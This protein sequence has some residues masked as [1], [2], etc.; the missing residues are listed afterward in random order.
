A[1]LAISKAHFAVRGDTSDGNKIKADI[2]GNL[3]VSFDGSSVAMDISIAYEH[4]ASPDLSIKGSTTAPITFA[5]FNSFD[6]ADG[7]FSATR[8]HR[9]WT[10]DLSG[11]AQLN[12]RDVDVKVDIKPSGDSAV[13][14]TS[15]TLAQLVGEANLPGLDDV[16]FN[17]VSLAKNSASLSGEIEGIRFDLTAFK[18]GPENKLHI[19]IALP[20]ELDLLHFIPQLRDTGLPNVILND[21]SF[22]WVP[23]GASETGVEVD[24]LPFS[25]A[26]IL[27]ASTPD[28]KIDLI[29]GVNVFAYLKGIPS[30]SFTD[31]MHDIGINPV[32]DFVS[33]V[34]PAAV[35]QR[36]SAA[37]SPG[38]EQAILDNLNIHWNVPLP[39]IPGLDSVLSFTDAKL[40]ITGT[41]NAQG[42]TVIDAGIS[43]DANFHV[44][45]DAFKLLVKIEDNRVSG[46]NGVNALTFLAS[47]T[48]SWTHPIG[49]DW[50]TLDNIDLKITKTS[51][52]TANSPSDYSISLDST[53]DIGG[54]PR[55]IS[56]SFTYLEKGISAASFT[57]D[58]PLAL[59]D[60][61][62]IAK[63][64]HVKEFS[65]TN[66]IISPGGIEADT[67]L[68]GNALDFY[69]F[70][71]GSDWNFAAVQKEF[72]FSELIPALD[73]TPAGDFKLSEAALL[74]TSG[75]LN[76]LLSTMPVIAQ[77]A[78]KNIYGSG[79]AEV[80]IPSGLSM[81]AAFGSGGTD[82]MAKGMARMGAGDGGVLIGTIG[83]VFGGTPDISLTMM[84]SV[85]AKPAQTTAATKFKDGE[86]LTLNV[87]LIGDADSFV[88]QL[89]MGTDITTKIDG[90]TLVF[91]SIIELQLSDEVERILFDMT[92]KTGNV[93]DKPLVWSEPY[94]IPGFE[95]HSVTLDLGIDE[96]GAQHFGLA[97][98]FTLA[99]DTISFAVDFDLAAEASEFPQDIAFE[100]TAT[101]I[102]MDFLEA[103]AFQM[104]SGELQKQ[105]VDFGMSSLPV[106]KIEGIL[107]AKTG[108][109]GPVKLAFVSPGAQD[110]NLGLT[111][112]GFGLQGSMH[113]LGQDLGEIFVAIG[114][115]SGIFAWG[116]IA[117]INLGDD[118]LTLKS[119]NFAMRLPVPGLGQ[120]NH[121]V[122]AKANAA[123]KSQ[124]GLL[125]C[126]NSS[127]DVIGISETLRVDAT[128]SGMSFS[129][130]LS[131][132]KYFDENLEFALSGVDLTTTHPSL[133]NADFAISGTLTADVG[134]EIA[135]LMTDGIGDIFSGFTT[136]LQSAETD[137]TN[138][139]ASVATLTTTINQ[140]R[141]SVRAAKQKIVDVVN[142]AQD[143]V[144]SIDK[145]ITHLW[146]KYHGCHGWGK[147][148]CKAGYG[149]EIGSEKGV[150]DVAN[151][152]LDAAKALVNHMP[153]DLSPTVW[154]NILLRTTADGILYAAEKSIE[155]LVD[156]DDWNTKGVDLVANFTGGSVNIKH[157][158]FN[159]SLRALIAS[160]A[161]GGP[162]APVDLA[163]EA[164]IFGTNFSDNF[165]FNIADLESDVASDFS[166]LSL[167]AYY[168]IDRIFMHELDAVPTALTSQLRGAIGK[169]IDADQA[170]NRR[171]LATNAT[172]FAN[173]GRVA[174]QLQ[175]TYTG[176]SNSY[177]FTQMT[178]VVS[179][180]DRLP[181]SNTF[182]GDVIEIGNTGYCLSMPIGGEDP[183]FDACAAQ[184][185]IG[186]YDTV[187]INNQKL[188]TIAIMD[189]SKDT[190]YVAIS[191]SASRGRSCLSIAGSWANQEVSYGSGANSMSA[192]QSVF[193]PTIANAQSLSPAVDG[194]PSWMNCD[195][196]NDQ[197]NWKILEHGGLYFQIINR[198]TQDCAYLQYPS[199]PQDY[200]VSSLAMISC[201]GADSQV[202][203]LAPADPP[204]HHLVGTVIKQAYAQMNPEYDDSPTTHCIAGGGSNGWGKCQNNSANT[205][206]LQQEGMDFNLKWNYFQDYLNRRRFVASINTNDEM[207][208]R[209]NAESAPACL[210]FNTDDGGSS[211]TDPSLLNCDATEETQWLVYYKVIG[212]F[213]LASVATN[214]DSDGENVANSSRFV[215]P[216]F[217]LSMPLNP[218]AGASWELNNSSSSQL[219][220]ANDAAY[221]KSEQTNTAITARVSHW[222]T[223]KSE[224]DSNK[225]IL[226][227]GK[228]YCTSDNTLCY[229][230]G[231]P[232]PYVD[233]AAATTSTPIVNS[234]PGTMLASLTNGT[235]IISDDMSVSSAATV[236]AYRST[237]PPSAKWIICK[238][239]I[240]DGV[241]NGLHFYIPGVIESQG[242]AY[243]LDNQVNKVN[244]MQILTKMVDLAWQ[245]AGAGY[246]PSS[247]VPTGRAPITVAGGILTN[248]SFTHIPPQALFSC[249]SM[250]NRISYIGWTYEGEFCH[251]KYS[252][253]AT[254]TRNFQ[255]LTLEGDL[256][257]PKAAPAVNS[258]QD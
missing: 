132:G 233:K 61:A 113:W 222:A 170:A 12:G 153:I 48:E 5:F 40:V 22:L 118:L 167:M 42:Q 176:F 200:D 187:G 211:S 14:T 198:A 238:G 169:V 15:S 216:Q 116:D 95:L 209:F 195:I 100:G 121:A 21:V 171:R 177:A 125:F 174:T 199:D 35:F 175:N 6:I 204:T 136:F 24:S 188:T 112:I 4:G 119:N 163:I 231:P 82:T 70:K 101:F 206:E 253:K 29:P 178:E 120:F 160:I 97:G 152:V 89:G 67:T 157:A 63:L 129:S 130:S 189:G 39:K 90:D 86:Q 108:I 117:D 103:L 234:N 146:S 134:E 135:L 159:G 13:F 76:G 110:P 183:G 196:G 81:V 139:R 247:A 51:S 226:E 19:G 94:G 122:E 165:A 137:I 54:S 148:L 138:D 142:R 88:G 246:L 168:G 202:F 180:L 68:H 66:L 239:P 155:G 243:E 64:P 221:T 69:A 258:D 179:P 115:L 111:S 99:Q 58:G 37:P 7:K 186:D 161:P 109:V 201:I 96:D 91:D 75:E 71:H 34:M 232:S 192:Y 128:S 53:F 194:A 143:N 44:K 65:I 229:M 49:I 218:V 203:K 242:C 249:R 20:D 141:A 16:S 252:G 26:H 10:V 248:A 223:I 131:F 46:P 166:Q 36:H 257:E 251:L 106:P 59:P 18:R 84:L 28:T 230:T 92:L 60:I 38:I 181:A 197:Q 254:V 156:L 220:G 207:E 185:Q 154:S 9:E 23:E 212:G 79:T 147:Y 33:G 215:D 74:V 225:L 93:Q 164:E 77:N 244:Q 57:L 85:G 102:E 145:E 83:G 144:D 1:T 182:S 250:I 52:T 236:A 3:A 162:A 255:V 43:G 219:N 184:G 73:G 193:T 56:T 47:S 114:P 213:T 205:T 78:L 107:D 190:G 224:L 240:Y 11:R 210:V 124:P 55:K 104:I 172:D 41:Q 80:D 241:E 133:S 214:S 150:L 158:S 98:D 235:Q 227:E 72:E 30:P 208:G 140:E 17:R 8:S 25:F 45:D 27:S 151:G 87:T 173:Y 217:I 62:G 127:I 237:P 123:C 149:V 2:N 256:A 105:H 191:T 126:L 50:L 245:P 32:N 228:E 31:F